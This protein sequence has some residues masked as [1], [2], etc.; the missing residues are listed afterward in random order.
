MVG[1]FSMGGGIALQLALRHPEM[2]A[3]A[4]ALSSYMCDDAAAYKLLEGGLRGSCRRD[5][6]PLVFRTPGR[7]ADPRS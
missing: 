6:S 2:L 7:E 5:P 4:F 1:G 3:G